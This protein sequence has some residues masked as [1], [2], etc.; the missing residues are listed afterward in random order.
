MAARECWDIFFLQIWGKKTKVQI[1]YFFFLPLAFFVFPIF[2]ILF[3]P[4]PLFSFYFIYP[5]I[6]IY[7][8]SN[9]FPISD[10]LNHLFPFLYHIVIFIFSPFGSI[11]YGNF[12]ALRHISGPCGGNDF[13]P[14]R[15]R[16]GWPFVIFLWDGWV[17]GHFLPGLLV[18]GEKPKAAENIKRHVGNHV[19]QRAGF[20]AATTWHDGSDG[21]PKLLAGKG[22][23]ISIGFIFR[24]FRM[25]PMTYFIN[26]VNILGQEPHGRKTFRTHCHSNKTFRLYLLRALGT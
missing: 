9:L 22:E 24:I 23:N 19:Q 6:F 1:I 13:P 7:L 14:E 18:Q 15:I 11:A 16:L 20:P 3:S 17:D 4:T 25:H 21:V 10:K 12:Q 2:Y 5:S 8:P 26:T